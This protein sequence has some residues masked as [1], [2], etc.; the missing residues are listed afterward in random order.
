[1][2]MFYFFLEY[3]SQFNFYPFIFDNLRN[4]TSK[5]NQSWGQNYQIDEI[6]N[7]ELETH[8]FKIFKSELDV[9]I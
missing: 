1:M 4:F 8:L 7:K 2:I 3:S 5:L 9:I 6:W